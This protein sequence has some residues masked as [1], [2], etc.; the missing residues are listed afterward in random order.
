MLVLSLKLLPEAPGR[1]ETYLKIT[2]LMLSKTPPNAEHFTIE[3]SSNFSKRS[4]T[5]LY[6]EEVNSY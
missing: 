1:H 6:K 4:H 2:G 3:Y 5:G